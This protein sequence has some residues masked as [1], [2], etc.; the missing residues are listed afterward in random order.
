MRI[1]YAADTSPNIAFHSNLWRDN[2]FLSLVDLGHDVVEFDFDFRETFQ[3]I[4]TSDPRHSSFIKKNRG[5][6]SEELLKQIKI[7]HAKKPLDLFFSY[8]YDACIWPEVIDEIRSMGIKTV[9]WFCNGSYQIHLVK[10]ISPHYDW[11]LV[12]EK[13]R[14]EDY[15]KMGANPIYC[16]EAANPNIYKPF[17]LTRDFDVTFVGQAYGERPSYVHHLLQKGLDVRV[18]GPGW[19]R[20][21]IAESQ[22]FF[23]RFFNLGSKVLVAKNWKG[24]LNKFQRK[25]QQKAVIRQIP[26]NV[27][28]GILSD[29]ELVKIFS[30]SKI[31]LGLS[32]CGDPQSTG[33]RILQV[34]LRDFEVPM[35]GG[36]YVVEYMEELEQF[37]EVGKEIVCYSCLDDLTEKIKYYLRNDSEREKIR[38]A[39]YERCLREHT[40]KKRFEKVFFEMGLK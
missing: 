14:I 2:L 28:G 39:G 1:F 19:G 20:D 34:R 25:H 15:K 16:Q 35:S 13:F 38:L 30:R 17:E 37:F 21:S 29:Q 32:A 7:E 5:K 10:E 3:R 11:C 23:S 12:P 40:W 26:Q 27:V 31:N 8:F 22:D 4:N 24:L 18:W 36:F 33:S 9:N 6:V